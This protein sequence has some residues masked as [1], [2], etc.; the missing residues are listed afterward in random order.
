[1]NIRNINASEAKQLIDENKNNSEFVIMDVRTP[2]EYNAAK[3]KNSI[4]Y[5]IYGRDFVNKISELDKNKIYFIYCHS[6]NRSFMAA[7]I[8]LKLGFQ[9]V[10]N[11]ENGIIEWDNLNYPL[12]FQ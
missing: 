7:N 5:D 4:N 2:E 9:N 8:M 6:G 10:Y 1:M 11:L 12:V 3:L